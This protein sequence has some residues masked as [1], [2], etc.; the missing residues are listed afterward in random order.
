[1]SRHIRI[2][3]ACVV[4]VT[5]GLG[6]QQRASASQSVDPG[7]LNPPPFGM[8]LTCQATGGGVI[9]NSTSVMSGPVDYGSCG[10][11]DILAL[12]NE[13]DNFTFRY[14][15]SGNLIQFRVH[16]ERHAALS[17]S[18]TGTQGVE[19]INYTFTLDLSTLGDF[20]TATVT[21]AGQIGKFTVQGSGLGNHD[22]G[23]QIFQ[24]NGDVIIHGPHDSF[25]GADIFADQCAA[26]AV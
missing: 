19:T 2:V 14:D 5:L 26:L 24:S 13:K 10:T 4:A 22:V 12:V 6:S 17:N 7:S 1:M 11:F 23:L 9:C 16:T 25:Y 3:S 18:V 21:F 20:N 15:A 8:H